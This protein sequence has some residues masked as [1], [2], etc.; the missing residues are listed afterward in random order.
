MARGGARDGQG[1][2]ACARRGACGA[3]GGAPPTQVDRPAQGPRCA[4]PR[5]HA[6][7]TQRP[8]LLRVRRARAHRSPRLRAARDIHRARLL[9]WQARDGRDRKRRGCAGGRGCTRARESSRLVP[10]RGVCAAGTRLLSCEFTN[11]HAN[12]HKHT[13]PRGGK[14]PG[15]GWAGLK[16]TQPAQRSSTPGSSPA[17]SSSAASQLPSERRPG[18][19]PP[20]GAESSGCLRNARHCLRTD[21]WSVSLCVAACRA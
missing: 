20:T 8:A 3:G 5:A 18:A 12:T 13:G 16:P 6:P 21:G 11:P 9:P 1:R 17:R 7:G 15:V 2:C 10:L 14:C 19:L 4:R